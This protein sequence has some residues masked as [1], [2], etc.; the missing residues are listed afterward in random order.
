M[1]ASSGVAKLPSGPLTLA[2]ASR[3]RRRLLENAGFDIEVCV[4]AIDEAAIRQSC[5]A[6][7][8]DPGDVAVILAEM[9]GRAAAA[10]TM[11]PPGALLLAAD[12][13]LEIDGEMIGKPA[14]RAA[15]ATQL[16]RLQGDV[17]RL[18]T[19]AVIF[20]DG[21]RIWHHL[22][23]AELTMRP[24][25][26]M[27]IEAYLDHLGDAALWSPGS[28]QIESLGMHLFSR[29]SGC[30][31]GILGLPLLEIATFLRGHGLS[32]SVEARR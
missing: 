21:E 32:L 19:A 30:H 31:Y 1:T 13:I 25:D 22:A 12:Q 17:H 14:D 20:R 11:S 27:E 2:S 5:A 18:L 3:T 24:L 16:T 6:E 23:T 7:N 9:K 26:D 29:I 28:Y 8:I 4:A 15:A 10:K